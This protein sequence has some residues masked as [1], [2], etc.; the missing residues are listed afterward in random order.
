[1][2]RHASPDWFCKH[3]DTGQVMYSSNNPRSWQRSLLATD[4]TVRLQDLTTNKY[5]YSDQITIVLGNANALHVDLS[6]LQCDHVD[7]QYVDNKDNT[8]SKICECG[9]TVIDKE[10]HSYEN[11]ACVCGHTL[12]AIVGNSAATLESMLQLDI[13]IDCSQLEGD[14]NYVILTRHYADGREDEVVRI[15]QAD[16]TFYRDTR[17]AASYTK[18]AAKEMGD[19]ITAV[20]YNAQ[21]QQL[22]IPKNDSIKAYAYRGLTAYAQIGKAPLST[23][24][25]D[26]L[27]Y[28]AAAQQQFGYDTANLVTADMTDT[29]KSW[30]TAEDVACDSNRVLGTG[31][32]T[33]TLALESAVCIDFVFYASVIGDASQWNNLYAIATFEDHYGEAKSVRVE[34][35]DFEGYRGGTDAQVRIDGLAAA[36]YE[37]LVTCVVYNSEGVEIARCVDSMEG[38]VNRALAAGTAGATLENLCK[39]MAKYMAAA[40]TQFHQ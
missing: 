24:L 32:R 2:C 39:L 21:G 25:V 23:L 7:A 13:L 33:T 22:S 11:N 3:P 17:Y 8:H 15:D 14:D 36:D 31:A 5:V 37:Q 35:A 4:Y 10:P 12:K 30:G 27:N 38:Y 26:M 28:G 18:I 20:V 19:E 34:G 9:V 29:Q 40:H 16:W 1:M 6:S